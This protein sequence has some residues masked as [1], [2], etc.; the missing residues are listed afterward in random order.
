LLLAIDGHSAAGKSTLAQA[1]CDA[2]P[3]SCLVRTDDFYRP[4]DQAVRFALIPAEGYEHYYDWQRLKQEV[5][6]PLSV[7][8]P[9]RFQTYD[10]SSNQLGAS[11]TLEPTDFVV[12]EGC[13]MAR[14][15]LRNFFAVI[16]LVETPLAERESRQSKRANATQ[17]WLERWDAAER[18]HLETNELHLHADVVF[19]GFANG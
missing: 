7:G 13:Y 16:A 5:L 11:K 4:M 3:N 18:Y 6:E 8:K 9:A 1:V 17:A 10:W 15:E 14:P 19:S 2:L 12:V